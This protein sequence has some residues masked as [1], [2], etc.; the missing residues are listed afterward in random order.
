[1]LLL[2][3][4]QCVLPSPLM[5]SCFVLFQIIVQLFLSF[6]TIFLSLNTEKTNLSF[7]NKNLQY[8]C[9]KITEVQSNAVIF[10]AR[11]L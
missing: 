4:L 6:A 8:S 2:I 7:R 10:L 1:M 3:V 9:L 11:K 5:L